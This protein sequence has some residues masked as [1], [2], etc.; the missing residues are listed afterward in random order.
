MYMRK[1]NYEE[2][3]IIGFSSG[4]DKKYTRKNITFGKSTGF[5]NV[6]MLVKDNSSLSQGMSQTNYII[7]VYSIVYNNVDKQKL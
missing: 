4:A 2:F 1:A 5:L 6:I 7:Y 3:K